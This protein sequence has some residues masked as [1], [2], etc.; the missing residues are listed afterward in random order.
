MKK[1]LGRRATPAVLATLALAAT[2]GTAPAPAAPAGH[3]HADLAAC[4]ALL[5]D[6]VLGLG[7]L[8]AARAATAR[9]GSIPREPA[10]DTTDTEIPGTP[11]TVGKHFAATV[12]VYF[13]V[14]NKGPAL[15]DGNVPDSQI[16]AQIDVINRTFAGGRGGANTGF[17]FMLAGT[18]RTTN[19]EWFEMSTSRAERDAKQALHRGGMNALNIYSNSGAGF[20]GWSYFPKDVR[21][22]PYIDGIVI[23]FGSMPG[24][25]IE[26]FNLGFTATHE[27]GHWLGLFH[28][29]QN[30]CSTTGD[31]IDDTPAERFP[32]SGCPEGQ[33]T[34]TA[35]GVD[36]IHNYMDYSDDPCYEEFT[37]GQAKRMAQ[38][39][40]YFRAP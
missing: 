19:E 11:P 28:T 9:G 4:N 36:P 16:Q 25:D 3:N 14:I 38:Q 37:A 18:D 33:D 32:T 21:G 27:A 35:P 17:R 6:S 22:K 2:V 10:I 12:P 24:G 30:G 34:C 1:R 26:D 8:D 29:F 40:L 23:A 20:L 5:P 15:A 31:R 7:S 13:H 39:W